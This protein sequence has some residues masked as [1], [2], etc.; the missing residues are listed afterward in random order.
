[1]IGQTISHYKILEKLGEG[2]M[3]VVYKAQDIRLD[4]PVA[5][6]FF[7]PD[8]SADPV[9]KQRFIQ[10]ARIASSIDHPNVVSIYEIDEAEH[11]NLFIAMAYYR[12][13]TLDSKIKA[14][15]LPLADAINIALQVSQGL[16]KSHEL[17]IV[18]QDIKPPNILIPE[19]GTAKILDFGVATL[20]ES[21]SR[22]G[23][24]IAG[25]LPYMSPEQV[26]GET[27]DRRTDIWS[28]AV[29]LYEMISGKTPFFREYEQSIQYSILNER[30][31]PI[32]DVPNDVSGELHSIFDK[33][34]QKRPED[35]FQ[36]ISEMMIRLKS[37]RSHIA[38]SAGARKPAIAVLPFV[39]LS[40]EQDQEYFCD[41]LTEELIDAL[42]KVGE[43]RVASRSSS[44]QF[45][46]KSED[47]RHIGERLNVRTVLEGSVRKSGDRLRITAQLVDVVSGYH[48]WSERFDRRLPDIFTIQEEIA[49]RIVQTL[50]IRLMPDETGR[51]VKR[52]TE[53]L[54]AY[55]LYLQG[56]YHWNKRT[57]ESIR[58]AIDFF[59]RAIRVDSHYAL[60]YTGIADSYALLDQYGNLPIVESYE[61]ARAAAQ[62][63]LEI[64]PQLAEAHA[65][66][67][68]NELWYN[69]NWEDGEKRLR[70]AIAL[71]P[72]YATARH[73]LAICLNM[74]G[75]FDESL[76][77][78]DRALELDPLSLII[79]RDKGVN[80]YYARRYDEAI[81]Q[82]RRVL[83]LDPDFAL[84]HR[85]LAIAYE[86]K[87]MFTEALSENQ[88]WGD[89]TKDRLRTEVACGH[90]YAVSGKRG[91]AMQLLDRI[92]Q[93]ISHRK[94]LTYA[95]GLIYTG[96]KEI[97]QAFE[98]FDRA[99]E[100]RASALGSL[101][102][103]PKLDILRA[104]P[105]YTALLKKMRIQP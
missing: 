72:N 15:R 61:R 93:E 54:E 55:N 49:Q 18:H 28:L 6:K 26:R 65:S 9:R 91:D 85:L 17:G 38:S 67:A 47:I 33:A 60:A 36:N 89:L 2:G 41:G 40:P 64:D 45:K 62:K 83:D 98:W 73:W 50:K 10:E 87:E 7:P 63:A 81:E 31:S 80:L 68:E 30:H 57:G 24:E 42:A 48:L 29:V 59:N 43:L 77:E 101:K 53:N 105:R 94:D 14:G 82:G 37:V 13:I 84:A 103:D 21:A 97:D 35:R 3:G 99:Y 11:D 12:G 95:V 88:I 79:L 92:E 86:R 90:V 76:D 34:L 71:N 19:E 27:T 16:A 100:Y 56:R 52:S 25:T 96:L 8:L 69:W 78:M 75:H 23:M 51:L 5:L 66:F 1:M 74:K 4:R 70:H 44:F 46:E 104:D 32:E 22:F 58:K 102:V 39:D 20:N